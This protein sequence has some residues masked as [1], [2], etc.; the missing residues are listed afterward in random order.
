MREVDIRDYIGYAKELTADQVRKLPV[1]T[2]VIRHSFDRSG[3]HVTLETMV[4]QS[5]RSRVLSYRGY[6]GLKEVKKITPETERMCY[7][8]AKA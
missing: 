8:E 7:T 1:G 6:D 4:A 2:K 3:N 5:G